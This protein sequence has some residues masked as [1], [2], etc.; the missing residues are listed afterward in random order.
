MMGRSVVARPVSRPSTTRRSITPGPAFQPGASPSKRDSMGLGL[1]TEAAPS[2]TADS[3]RSTRGTV[4]STAG[5][6][7]PLAA[8]NRK[9]IR[10]RRKGRLLGLRFR[11]SDRRRLAFDIDLPGRAFQT[12][13]ELDAEGL[14]HQILAPG[15]EDPF[16][17][18]RALNREP[19]A[20][21]VLEPEVFPERLD[22]AQ[23]LPVLSF[24]AERL[25]K[26]GREHADRGLVARGGIALLRLDRDF[27]VLELERERLALDL[28]FRV[29]PPQGRPAHPGPC[30]R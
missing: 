18:L 21:R 14:F 5:E 22:A 26:L 13:R 4:V 8:R 7:Q 25:R 20:L 12:R 1:R 28:L 24:F 17:R 3:K 15:R 9:L 2:T 10:I 23:K 27:D 29:A 11:E 6:E 30:P 16:Q 19:D